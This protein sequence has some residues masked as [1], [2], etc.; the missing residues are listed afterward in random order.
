MTARPQGLTAYIAVTAA[1]W[2]FMLT[3]GALRIV[4]TRGRGMGLAVGMG[5]AL[6][7]GG[8]VSLDTGLAMALLGDVPTPRVRFAGAGAPEGEAADA[9]RATLER[10]YAGNIHNRYHLFTLG[11]SYRLE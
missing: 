8:P 6:S 2:S 5:Y 3:D 9:S 1:Y 10:A 11:L 7:L 4:Q